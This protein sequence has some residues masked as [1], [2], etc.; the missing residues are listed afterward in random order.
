MT[1][2][3]KIALSTLAI[4]AT[5]TLTT[6]LVLPRV[7]VGDLGPGAGPFVKRLELGWIPLRLEAISAFARPRSDGAA[8]SEWTHEI[9]VVWWGV[10]REGT[11]NSISLPSFDR[12]YFENT[13][14]HAY[15]DL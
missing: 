12:A 11:P 4:V 5:L 3:R 15:E 2:R 6:D 7:E 10:R 14:R 8:V 13:G 1:R 9:A